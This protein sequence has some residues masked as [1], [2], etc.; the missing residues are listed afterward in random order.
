MS[1]AD[2]DDQGRY[3][4]L[5]NVKA[6]SWQTRSSH[7]QSV[8]DS[9]ADNLLYV[10]FNRVC[11]IVKLCSSSADLEVVVCNA[12][13]EVRL[14]QGTNAQ[15]AGAICKW[16]VHVRSAIVRLAPDNEL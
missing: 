6:R 3:P 13:E 8:T 16:T 2:P 14:D 4:Q 7:V 15:L 1:R 9:E 10:G 5:M 11:R 12:L